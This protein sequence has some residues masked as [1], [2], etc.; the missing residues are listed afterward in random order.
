MN[1][2]SSFRGVELRHFSIQNAL[3]ASESC[4]LPTVFMS[5]FLTLHND[6]SHIENVRLL[7]C[8]HF[9]NIFFIFGVLNLEFFS[10]KCLEGVWFV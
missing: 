10:V 5:L 9:M 3:M 2:F 1:I 6:N 4:K 7:L 8:T